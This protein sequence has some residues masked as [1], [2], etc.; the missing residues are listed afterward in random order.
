MDGQIFEL[1]LVNPGLVV[2]IQSLGCKFS[3]SAEWNKQCE[4]LGGHTRRGAVEA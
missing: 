3:Y 2:Q 1:G 4:H